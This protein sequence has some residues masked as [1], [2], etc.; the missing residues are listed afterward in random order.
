MCYIEGVRVKTSKKLNLRKT[1]MI[2]S[3]RKSATVEDYCNGCQMIESI[4]AI[5]R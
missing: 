1:G 3:V 5:L 4:R 2:R